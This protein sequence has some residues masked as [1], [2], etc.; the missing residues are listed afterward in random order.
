MHALFSHAFSYSAKYMRICVA[1]IRAVHFS[2]RGSVLRT[3]YFYGGIQMK[4]K[5]LKKLFLTAL[6]CLCLCPAVTGGLSADAADV[7]EGGL[8]LSRQ[9]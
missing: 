7:T 6:L 5:A 4:K 8:D 3:F 9:R 2:V 1:A